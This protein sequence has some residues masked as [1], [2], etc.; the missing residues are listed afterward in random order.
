M[1]NDTWPEREDRALEHSVN[2]SNVHTQEGCALL[3]GGCR[4]W[5]VGLAPSQGLCLKHPGETQV[6]PWTEGPGRW[7]TPSAGSCTLSPL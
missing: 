7:P 4:P 3:S 2:G 1:E 5:L 6:G